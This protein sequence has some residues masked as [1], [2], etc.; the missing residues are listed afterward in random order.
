VPL[1]STFKALGYSPRARKKKSINSNN[2]KLSLHSINSFPVH[3][4]ASSFVTAVYFL[5]PLTLTSKEQLLGQFS[6]LN[7]TEVNNQA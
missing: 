7:F 2:L 3:T 4:G 1:P 5:L 6:D